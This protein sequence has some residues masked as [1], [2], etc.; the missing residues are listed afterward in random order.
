[1]RLENLRWETVHG[2]NTGLNISLFK[3]RLRADMDLYR[4]RTTDLFFDNLQIASH[5]GFNGVNMNV[6]TMD[7]Q[8]WEI[9]LWTQP[10]KNKD[11]TIGFDFNIS[12][13]QNVIRKISEYYPS[14]KGNVGNNG[15][16]M[17][18]LQVDNPFGSFYGYKYKGVYAD[19]EA[20]IA[21]GANGKPIIGPNG[22]I[23]YMHF[24]YPTIDYTFQ[25]GMPCM[26][27]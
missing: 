25:E 6:G 11:L 3:G 4:N 14:T 2:A 22:Q 8:G 19:K 23:V 24:N 1:M 16:Y 9:A 5:T 15:E 20:T 18:M 21:K 7:N 12:K 13:N 10:Y 27:T 26:K 17:R